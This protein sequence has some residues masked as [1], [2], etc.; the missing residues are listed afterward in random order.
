MPKNAI[1]IQYTFNHIIDNYEFI[2]E[3][4]DNYNDL[5]ITLLD[6]N[7][8]KVFNV[9]DMNDNDFLPLFSCDPDMHFYNDYMRNISCDSK[10]YSIESFQECVKTTFI[11][12]P[13]LSF[14]HLNIH[15][16]PAHIVE[17]DAYLSTLDFSFDI[18]ALSETWL[19]PENADL[20]NIVGYDYIHKYRS[21][22]IGGGV[23]ILIKKP[24]NFT[25]RTD[26]CIFNDDIESVFIEID[27]SLI[28]EKKN[29]IIGCI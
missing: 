27:K 17:F 10:Y 18:I 4:S 2:S 3:L 12:V 22:R 14:S 8:N 1:Y 23:S 5:P 21:N 28:G 7:D 11:D 24:L 13:K 19:N 16:L 25:Y 29:V 15:S 20:Y 26:L 6:F 9:S